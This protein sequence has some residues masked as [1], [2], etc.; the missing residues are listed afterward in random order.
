MKKMLL[1]VALVM[2]AFVYA[3]AQTTEEQENKKQEQP[4]ESKEEQKEEQKSELMLAYFDY[5]MLVDSTETPKKE[6]PKEQPTENQEF[7]L[8]ADTVTETPKKEEPAEK[9]TEAQEFYS[10][11]DTITDTT[12]TQ[13]ELVMLTNDEE[14]K[15]ISLREICSKAQNTL[16]S[17]FQD[18][19]VKK[20]M[21]NEA[22]KL[23]KVVLVSNAD[24]TE[25]TVI[26]NENGEVVEEK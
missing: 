4:T 5:A 26:I 3:N 8:Y 25:K 19:T 12:K 24:Q 11:T 7:Y 17:N 16:N 20:V 23:T 1:S 10:Y 14:Y 18:Y 9:P 15:V 6:E 22:K 21:Y 13:T 2:G